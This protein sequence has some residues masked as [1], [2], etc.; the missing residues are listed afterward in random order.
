MHQFSFT[1]GKNA[2]DGFMIIDAMDLLYTNWF[3]G[4]VIV[5]S[6]SDF[7]SLA[8]R[9]KEQGMKVYGIGQGQTPESFKNACC[10]Q[11]K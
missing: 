1:T 3:D 4:F 5:S 2:T 11:T 9:L 10:G 7:T 8:I 6:D